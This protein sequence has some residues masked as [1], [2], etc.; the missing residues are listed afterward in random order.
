[1][2]SPSVVH[3]KREPFDVYIGRPGPWG[4]KYTI[5]Q[6]GSREQ[7]IAWFEEDLLRDRARMLQLNELRGQV[8]GCWCAPQA[9][10]GD[11]LARRANASRLLITCSRTWWDWPRATQALTLVYRRA[12]RL[13]LVSGHNPHGDQDLE[14]IW[15]ILGGQVET[16]P[17]DWEAECRPGCW[18]PYHRK[19]GRNG[20]EYCPAAGDWRN[21]EMAQLPGVVMCLAFLDRCKKPDCRRRT[22]PGQHYSHGASSCARYAELELQIPTKKVAVPIIR[23]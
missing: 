1:M 7:V 18:P 8:L 5:G 23:A 9:C 16:Y 4:N 22:L 14:R 17:A 3:C 15:T 2:S 19:R 13:I 11:V 10:H 20:R 12:P 6:D 21:E